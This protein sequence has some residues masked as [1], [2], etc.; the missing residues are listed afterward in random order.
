M[1]IFRKK[2]VV[3]DVLS[4]QLIFRDVVSDLFDKIKST[5]RKQVI[6]DFSQIESISRSVAQ[7]YLQQKEK[8]S[9]MITEINKSPQIE[10]MFHS[11]KTTKRKSNSLSI[12]NMKEISIHEFL[13][14]NENKS[15]R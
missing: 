7:E 3:K 12:D 13:K 10:K 11:V 9:I 1:T 5:K 2:I 15:V 6:L 14:S 8:Q 4:E